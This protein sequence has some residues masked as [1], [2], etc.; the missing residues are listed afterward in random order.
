MALHIGQGIL[1]RKVQ[2][3][4]MR[5]SVIVGPGGPVDTHVRNKIYVHQRKGSELCL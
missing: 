3:R 4:Y 1:C 2:Q 5:V